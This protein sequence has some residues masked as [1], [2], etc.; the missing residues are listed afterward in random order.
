[1]KSKLNK[2]MYFLTLLKLALDLKHD[3]MSNM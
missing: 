3:Y 2:S 1:M